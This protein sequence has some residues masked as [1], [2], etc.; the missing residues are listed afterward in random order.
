MNLLDILT[1]IYLYVYLSHF[2]TFFLS[3]IMNELIAWSNTN[4]SFYLSV[5]LCIFSQ[6]KACFVCSMQTIPNWKF[7]PKWNVA[8]TIGQW[9]VASQGRKVEIDNHWILE[10]CTRVVSLIKDLHITLPSRIATCP[11]YSL[12]RRILFQS[13]SCKIQCRCPKQRIALRAVGDRIEWTTN[14]R[15]FAA[16]FSSIKLYTTCIDTY[17]H[18]SWIQ[19][20]SIAIFTINGFTLELLIVR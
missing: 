9:S 15:T 19:T 14:N 4:I 6:K 17:F 18:Q 1:S 8:V 16:T 3:W 20:N 12:D 13:S 10:R 2:F 7:L 5:V 11:G